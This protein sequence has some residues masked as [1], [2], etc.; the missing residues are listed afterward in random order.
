MKVCCAGTG[1]K[2]NCYIINDTL[3]IEAGVSYK[4]L[5]QN[6]DVKQLKAVLISHSHKDHSKYTH[7]FSDRAIDCYMSKETANNTDVHPHRL[8]IIENN[9]VF[10]IA[11]YTIIPFL[12][13]HDVENFG[14][15]ILN[16]TTKEKILFATDTA[17][18]PYNFKNINLYMIEA[19]FSEKIIK[20]NVNN[21]TLSQYLA[22]RNIK[23]H[24]SLENAISFVNS[25]NKIMMQNAL[26]IHLSEKNSHSTYFKREF[27]ERTGIITE[28]AEK[29]KTFIF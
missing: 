14:Y 8:K 6:I 28:I 15:L 16:N 20:K 27:E 29:N 2:G 25:Q 17:Y 23:T 5:A 1:S 12:L 3:A 13:E 18:I 10:Y 9:K 24:M 4:E 21:N 26:L 19:N 11:E 22:N 7:S